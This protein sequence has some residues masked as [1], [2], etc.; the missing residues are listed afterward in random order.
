MKT[1]ATFDLATLISQNALF[2]INHSGG[3]DSQAMMIKML[4]MDIPA[5]QLVVVHAD[6]GTMEWEGTMAHAKQQADAA[7]LP[8][9]VAQAQDRQGET[10]DL[11]DM[12]N[13]KHESR[14]EVPSWPSADIRNCTSD[15]KRGPI[16]RELR[17][18]MKANGFKVVVSCQGIRAQESNSRAKEIPFRLSERKDDQ[19][20]GRTWYIWLPIFDMKI[21]EVFATVRQAGQELHPAYALGNERLSCVF[22]VMGSKTDLANGARHNPALFERYVAMEQKTGYFMHQSMRPLVELVAEGE[23]KLQARGRLAA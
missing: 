12:V 6:L 15:L 20:A 14:P 9:L 23:R 4:A 10:F 13:R 3:K 1:A 19:A 7:G 18:Y 16:A 2:A 5:R 21:D 17:R 22:C 8:F 11:L